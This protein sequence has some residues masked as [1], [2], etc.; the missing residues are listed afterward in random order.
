VV[1]SHDFPLDKARPEY[2]WAIVSVGSDGVLSATSTGGQRSSKVG[3]LKGANALLCMPSGPEPLRKGAK[4]EALLM[5]NL[6]SDL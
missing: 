3:S 2:H 6:R 1:L 4:V 5:G